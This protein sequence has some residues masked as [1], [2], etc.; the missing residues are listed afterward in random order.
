M[1]RCECGVITGHRCPWEGN[2]YDMITIEWMPDPLRASHVAAGSRGVYPHNGAARL[3][4]GPR[5]GPTLVS[6]DPG[7]TREVPDE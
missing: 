1:N 2:P 6:R 7:W 3:R 4:V 5:C